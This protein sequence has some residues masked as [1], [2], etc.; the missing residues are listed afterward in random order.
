MK[1]LG[2]L[3]LVLLL[4]FSFCIG[5]FV[6]G[7]DW[8]KIDD[9]EVVVKMREL[10]SANL[11][12][13]GS[14]K[15]NPKSIYKLVSQKELRELE[16][17][18][19]VDKIFPK[20][21]LHAFL[22]EAVEIINSTGTNNLGI[23][24]LNL[25]GTNQ[26]VCV[27]DSGVNFSH[28]DLTGK[29]VSCVVD[30]FN[31]ACAEDCSVSDDNGHGTHVAGIVASSGGITGVAPNVSL[32]G[33][34]ILDSN[35][36]GSGNNADLNNAIDWCVAQNVS[37]ITMSLGTTSL[38]NSVCDA[39]GGFGNWRDS[40]DAAVAQNISV[41]AASGNDENTTHISS[42]ACL[43]NA[44]AIGNV[45]D[46]GYASVAWVSGCTDAPAVLDQIVCHANRNSLVKLFA[47]GAMINSTDNDGDYVERGGTSMA[48]PMVA[49]AI[50]LI[51]QYLNLSGQTKTPAEIE[52]ALNDT[53]ETIEDSAGSGLNFSRINV[54]SAILSLDITA[55]A[56]TLVSP[57]DTLTNSSTNNT[58]NC[59]ATDWQL[60]NI[61][62]KVW[63]S[64]AL[65]YSETVNISG[66]SNSS[67]FN[68]T[69]MP[70][71]DYSWNCLASD[72]LGNSNY[73]VANFSLTI[74]SPKVIVIGIDGFQYNHYVDL[75]AAGVLTNFSRLMG[76]S[77]WNGTHNITG[78]ATT[79]TAPGNAE[80]QT[81]LNET[82][83][84]V[85][86]NTCANPVPE[87]TSIFERLESFDSEIV[88]GSIYGKT[89]C[90]IPG[91]VLGNTIS[92]IDWWQNRSTYSPSAWSDGTACDN[93]N[94]VATKATE[95]IGNYSNSSFYLFVY[96]GVPDCSGHVGG[97]NS[98]NYNNSFLNVD[99]G[100]GVL[101]DS[102]ESNGINGSV[103]IIITADHG[104]NEGTTSHSTADVNTVM[105]PLITN[106]ATMVL[107]NTSDGIREQ[108]EIVPTVL[109][110]FRLPTS[111]YTDIINNGCDSMISNADITS[112]VISGVSSSVSLTGATINWTTDESS[113]SSINYGLSL[114]LGTFSSDSDFDLSHSITLSGLSSASLYYYNIT[115]C[116]LSGNCETSSNNFTTS[117]PAVVT[118]STGGG[119]GGGTDTVT[120]ADNGV[121][122][123]TSAEVSAGY[124]QTLGKDEK[125]NFSIFDAEGGRHLLIVNA[126]G[127][128]HV[129]LT[130]ESDPINLT[131]GIGQS[132]KLNLTSPVYYDLLVKLNRIVNG[133]AELMIQLI[134][135]PI[136]EK[137]V[138]VGG[139]GKI[140]ETEILLIKDY[141]WVVAALI[142]VLALAV[143]AF[144]IRGNRKKLKGE[145]PKKDRK[146]RGSKK[147][148]GK[149]KNEETEA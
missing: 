51:N 1:R 149:D 59:N 74:D 33:V 22:Q 63:N 114:S 108:C 18:G 28:S 131:L 47:P 147:K 53:G 68:L 104:W 42:P 144:I 89:T 98:I 31:Q 78:H 109:D 121:F 124:T 35:G 11:R 113:N 102:L 126:V 38:Y 34:K 119:G 19:R 91:G 76:D 3:C 71:G 130:I 122:N 135:E 117:S 141:F 105:I 32:I 106:N 148:N 85:T 127:I 21:H 60:A 12:S 10:P 66:T 56:V 25:T 67:D 84:G 75:Y 29:N 7:K 118:P 96:F 39:V 15:V 55:P 137:I 125:V 5:G 143:I 80:L 146:K 24:G 81:G 120:A 14:E 79:S 136:E 8:K 92:D 83:T 61:T 77:G 87:G 41:I 43:T 140:V 88:T 49:G 142:V 128:D 93:S 99:E 6:E 62:L 138:E 54:Y 132:A 26:T 133:E 58:F 13:M 69:D 45:Y 103:Q 134:N 46:G 95:F 107:G 123:V 65:Y 23:G 40:I 37:V 30:C 112:P 44:S 86:D 100:L 9:S 82:L 16:K 2:I 90:Y 97:D 36:D 115:S 50:A 101:L 94:D 27:I 4:A 129:N 64:S 17:L 73:S 72:V 110:Y 111:N 57:A 116:D 139:E 70:T 145:K 48:A 52:D 20:D